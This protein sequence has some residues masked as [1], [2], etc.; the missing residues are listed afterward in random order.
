MGAEVKN[1][2]AG[3]KKKKTRDSYQEREISAYEI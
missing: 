2:N 1:S 3:K